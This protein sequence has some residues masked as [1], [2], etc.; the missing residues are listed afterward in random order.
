MKSI[1][2]RAVISAADRTGGV[3]EGIARRLRNLVGV[4]D[5]ASRRVAAAGSVAAAAERAG[6][7]GGRLGGAAGLAAGRLAVGAAARVLAPAAAVYGGVQSVKRFADTDMALTRIG[8]TADATD[9]QITKLNKS[10]R[11][12]AFESGKSFDEVTKGLDSLVAGGMD[13]PQAMPALPAIVKTAQAAGAEVSDMANTTLALNQA[14]GIATDKMQSS[15][16]VLVT[17]GKAGKFELKDMARYMASIA[18]AAAAIGLKGEAG[19]KTIVAMMQ[20]IRAG[21]GTSEEAAASLQNIFA[22]MESE[23][24][25]GKFEKFGIDLRKEMDK[26]RKSGR[27][28]LTVFLELT[29]KATKGDLSKIPQLFTDMEFAR[30]MRALMQYRDLMKEVTE[31]LGKSSGSAMKDFERVL[32]RPKVAVDRLSESFDRLKEAAGA[33]LDALGVSKGMDWVARKTEE[34]IEYRNKPEVERA[35]VRAETDRKAGLEKEKAAVQEKIRLYESFGNNTDPSVMDRIKGHPGANIGKLLA[36]LRLKLLAIEGAMSAASPE[37]LPPI[38]SEKEIEAVRAAQEELRK[39][40]EAEAARQQQ[41]NARPGTPLPQSD[42]RKARPWEGN[43]LD[44]PP[45]KAE[46]TGSAEVKG[47]TTVKVEVEVKPTP[48]LIQAVASAKANAAKLS[49]MISANGAGSTGRSSPDAAPGGK[50]VS[51]GR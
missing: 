48:E 10:V 7:A 11:D 22:K 32:D 20:T 16:D 1:E 21:T 25:T 2:A 45:V 31:K 39:K 50:G 5:N 4:A 47:E 36:D 3:F 9:E 28:L 43:I 46:L 37:D 27:D 17:G 49:G 23:T 26:A 24:T 15:F 42:P 40:S 34:A 18:P 44:L 35:R 8:I 12:L 38:M 33:A 13:L 30:G 19:L 29:E 51:G 41:K 6:Y 14:L